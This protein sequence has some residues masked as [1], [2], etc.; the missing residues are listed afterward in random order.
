MSVLLAYAL[1][2]FAPSPARQFSD[3]IVDLSRPH[4]S[5]FDGT[6]TDGLGNAASIALFGERDGKLVLEFQPGHAGTGRAGDVRRFVESHILG[7]LVWTERADEQQTFW[8]DVNH[9]YNSRHNR[10]RRARL[11]HHNYFGSA[12]GAAVRRNWRAQW[13]VAGQAPTPRPVAAH[14]QLTAG[15]IRAAKRHLAAA[16]EILGRHGL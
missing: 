5:I 15:E 12:D 11:Y 13:D 14:R 8:H 10:S 6:V 4:C 2:V 1:R 7:P 3:G 16:Q 9:R